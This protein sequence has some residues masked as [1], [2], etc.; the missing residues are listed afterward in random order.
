MFSR[1]IFLLIASGLVIVAS[2][3]CISSKQNYSVLTIDSDSIQA[4]MDDPSNS[5]IP[6]K[7][8]DSIAIYTNNKISISSRKV[9]FVSMDVTDM[10]SIRI[11]GKVV[12]VYGDTASG[13]EDVTGKIV[14]VNLEDIDEI[15][16]VTYEEVTTPYWQSDHKAAVGRMTWFF[17][18]IGAVLVAI[19]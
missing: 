3:G 8:G 2:S 9:S 12:H 14:E 1:K 5:A 10:D 16:G 18:L 17:I 19:L 11:K 7:A 13:Q 4:F 15:S 6:L